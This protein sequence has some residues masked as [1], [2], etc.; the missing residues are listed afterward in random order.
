[1]LEDAHHQLERFT[2][3]AGGCLGG[4]TAGAPIWAVDPTKRTLRRC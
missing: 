1:M 3:Y 4:D 2:L